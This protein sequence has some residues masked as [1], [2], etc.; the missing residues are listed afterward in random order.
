MRIAVLS[1]GSRGDVQP[2]AALSVALAARG[3]EVRLISH[4]EYA[5]LVAGRGVDYRALSGDI[6]ADF[7]AS[8]AGQRMAASGRNAVAAFRAMVE[9]TRLQARDWGS[10]IRD[11]AQGVDLL[12][13]ELTAG[14]PGATLAESWRIP[15]VQ[16]CLQPVWR[17]RTFPSPMAP[18]LPFRL[19]GALNRLHHDVVTQLMWQPFRSLVNRTRR[20]VADLGPWPLFGPFNRFRREGRPLLMAF[21]PLVVPPPPDWDDGITVTGYWYLDRQASWS[22][23]PALDAFIRSGPP[24]V[25]VGFGSMGIGDADATTETILAALQQ[26]GCR[27]VVSAGWGGLRAA[28][29]PPEIFA[30]EAV[31]HDW[32]FPLMAAIVHHGGA[33][34]TAAALR[35]GVPSVVVPF[36]VDQ[37]FWAR[38]LR[39]CGVAPRAIPHGRLTVASL[40]AALCQVLH[41]GALRARAAELGAR[42]RAE[43]GLAQAVERIEA[44]ARG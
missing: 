29:L 5:E 2:Q 20:E 9:M 23:P 36:M 35:A 34:T 14:Y 10:Q 40:S 33:G 28:D 7:A 38:R 18:P 44:A 27:A 22:P 25:Y 11:L 32:L 17:T 4:G 24:P 12:V 1:L 6:R 8:A 15:W 26:S 31:P 13:P 39:E 30:T 41:D 42:I 37:F 3:H 21:S 16:V 19:P 43:E